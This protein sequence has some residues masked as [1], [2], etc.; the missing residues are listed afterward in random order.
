M[1]GVS[2]LL[3]KKWG[4]VLAGGG[5]KGAYQVGAYKALVEAGLHKN[6]VAM[7]G[8]SVGALNMVLFDMDD[9]EMTQSVWKGISPKQFLEIQPNKMFDGIEGFISREGLIDIV[10][11]YVNR[12]KLKNETRPMYVTLSRY[13]DMVTEKA[14]CEY[15]KINNIEY[16]NVKKVLLA[17]SALPIVYEPV[18]IGEYIYRDGGLTDNLP[19]K[20]LYDEGI[21]NFIVIMLSPNTKINYTQ[22]PNADFFEIRPSR[23][24]GDLLSGTLDFSSKGANIRMDMGY[25]ETKRF[26]KYYNDGE[27][28]NPEFKIKMME[29]ADEEYRQ[30]CNKYKVDAI[31]SYIENSISNVSSYFDKYDVNL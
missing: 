14:V 29:M 27:F 19:V 18:K 12:D 6:I 16:E 17:S 21:R 13:E 15:F 9:I 1:S 4:L 31:G 5:G 7:S 2:E 11:G 10:D 22:F 3:E 26:I 28:S 8:S 30:F 25:S 24:L 20:P 23:D